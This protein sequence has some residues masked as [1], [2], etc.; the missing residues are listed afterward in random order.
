MPSEYVAKGTA[1]VHHGDGPMPVPTGPSANVGNGMPRHRYTMSAGTFDGPRSP[2]GTKS[3]SVRIK[4]KLDRDQRLNRF[5][6]QTPP[7]SLAS[8]SG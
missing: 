7:M 3:M 1:P 6:P 5:P 8:S 2:P 4:H